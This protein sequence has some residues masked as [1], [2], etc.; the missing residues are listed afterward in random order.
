MLAEPVPKLVVGVKVA[1]LVRPVPLIAPR[2]PPETVKSPAV[3]FQA[4]LEPG[5][6]VNVKVM[7][8]VSPDLKVGTSEVIVT[9]GARVSIEIEGEDPAAPVFPAESE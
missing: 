3:P 7:A 8:A 1:D 9:L 4:K 5:S 2:V 6:S